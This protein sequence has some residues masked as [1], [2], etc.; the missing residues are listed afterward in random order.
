MDPATERTVT[1]VVARLVDLDVGGLVAVHLH[2]SAVSGGLRPDSDVDLLVT[3]RR[4]LVR[5]ERE[6]VMDLVLRRSGRR[7]TDGP[8]RPLELTCVVLDDV[9]PWRYPP[10]CD[11]L[12]GEW[13]R[14][15]LGEG[16]LPAPHPDPD[17]AVALTTTLQ[18]GTTLHGPDPAELFDPVPG[19]DL[20]RAVADGL[21]RL[22]DDLVGDER[23]VLLTLA[24]MVVTLETG[25]I[26]PKDVA[27]HRVAVGLRSSD[28]RLLELA[29]AAYTGDS[30]DDWT[31]ERAAAAATARRLAEQVRRLGG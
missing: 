21:G 6:A 4:S 25:E 3:T 22:L 17:L 28:R 18:H 14:D 11:L 16:T 13:L 30:P 26:V 9:R 20:R 2:G 23:N 29:A 12:Y 31:L 27:A 7:A 1:E 10:R 5:V 15:E 24:R 8:S 19:A